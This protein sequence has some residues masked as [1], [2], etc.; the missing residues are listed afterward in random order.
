M[1]DKKPLKN[2]K[3]AF[4]LLEE[5]QKSFNQYSTRY[6]AE[7][8]R[9]KRMIVKHVV[10]SP[11]STTVGTTAT[12]A[13]GSTSNAFSVAGV[14][15]GD[16][17]T[18]SIA[19]STNNVSITKVVAGTNQITVTFSADPG[20]GTSVHYTVSDPTGG[21]TAFFIAPTDITVVQAQCSFSQAGTDAGAVTLDIEKLADGEASGA[22]VS[23]L[24]S[25][26]DLKGTADTTQ[27]IRPTSSIFNK[28]LRRGQRLGLVLTGVP[29]DVKNVI[30]VVE[31]QYNKQYNQ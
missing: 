31:Y 9:G 13:G 28:N 15:A 21:F 12:W 3:G 24:S 18:A 22:G 11:H 26:F 30:I 14:S 6:N 7:F 23:V 1:S 29:T 20:A 19:T 4:S 25:T 17:V 2:S 10:E 27:S 16:V 5:T 8:L